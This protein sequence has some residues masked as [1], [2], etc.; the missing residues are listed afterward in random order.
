MSHALNQQNPSFAEACALYIYI[1]IYI[2]TSKLK[3]G[4]SKL[5]GEP[6]NSRRTGEN[7]CY[8]DIPASRH[9]VWHG[10][11]LRVQGSGILVWYGV[12]RRIHMATMSRT[13]SA[14]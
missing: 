2:H 8:S 1:Y 12:G 14:S 5:K 6:Q 4:S 13:R 7:T 10:V 9:L 3:P 11:R